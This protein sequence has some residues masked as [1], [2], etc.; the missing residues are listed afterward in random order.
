MERFAA[1]C[2]CGES[3]GSSSCLWHIFWQ[4]ATSDWKRNAGASYLTRRTRVSCS[5]GGIPGIVSNIEPW[6]VVAGP[7]KLMFLPDRLLVREGRR[8]AGVPY[9]KL[10]A[11]ASATRFIETEGTPIDT[12]QVDRT[13]RYVNKSGGPDRRFNN[14]RELPVVEYG[15]LVLESDS[16]VQVIFNLS[17]AEAARRT[18]QAIDVLSA[19]ASQLVHDVETPPPKMA[20]VERV[21]SPL[22]RGEG[23]P[24]VAPA[25]PPADLPGTGEKLGDAFFVLLK[26][27]AT[28]DR[29]FSDVEK[30]AIL[31]AVVTLLGGDDTM[32]AHLFS[33]WDD[34]GVRWVGS[35]DAL[36][37]VEELPIERRADFMRAAWAVAKADGRVTPKERERLDELAQR[38][39]PFDGSLG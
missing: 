19:L 4:A 39:G 37:V 15:Q 12:R 24:P 3:L 13:W 16:G 32:R 33:K 26:S 34:A 25:R 23:R 29:R 7:Q 5:A 11:T 17:R 10:R 31:D 27:V 6:S 21:I 20:L 1:A 35:A 2:A 8:L 38:L 14:N 28:A 36:A 30:T 18:A 22:S 9:E